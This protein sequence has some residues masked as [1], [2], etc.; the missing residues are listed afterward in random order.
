MLNSN[1]ES[2]SNDVYSIIAQI[3]KINSTEKPTKT[4][5]TTFSNEDMFNRLYGFVSYK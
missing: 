4:I 2:I 1:V 5:F 3:P